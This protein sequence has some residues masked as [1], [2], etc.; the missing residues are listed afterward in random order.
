MCFKKGSFLGNQSKSSGLY[1][2]W[3]KMSNR[4]LKNFRAKFRVNFTKNGDFFMEINFAIF[5]SCMRCLFLLELVK[6]TFQTMKH[7]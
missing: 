3:T 4:N 5:Y 2:I 1:F 7:I 6:K